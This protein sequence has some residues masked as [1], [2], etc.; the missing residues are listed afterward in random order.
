MTESV[1]KGRA[2]LPPWIQEGISM[3]GVLR[4]EDFKDLIVPDG[5]LHKLLAAA[6]AVSFHCDGKITK[7]DAV[8]LGSAFTWGFAD[9]LDWYSKSNKFSLRRA[10]RVSFILES[11]RLFFLA[12]LVWSQLKARASKFSMGNAMGFDEIIFVISKNDARWPSIVKNLEVYPQ[13]ITS[14][15]EVLDVPLYSNLTAEHADLT[16]VLFPG[17]FEAFQNPEPEPPEPVLRENLL[18]DEEDNVEKEE[19]FLNYYFQ[20]VKDSKESYS[21]GRVILESLVVTWSTTIR[22]YFRRRMLNSGFSSEEDRSA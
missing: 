15:Q 5:K 2:P 22:E 19:T 14:F 8:L 6:R 16:E 9:M 20:E 7:Q 4:E 17:I 10:K 1:K 3:D 12:Q 13:E 21:Q 11:M 18:H